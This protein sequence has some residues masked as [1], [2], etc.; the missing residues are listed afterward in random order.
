MSKCG[1]CGNEYRTGTMALVF[2]DGEALRRRVCP[3]CVRR[4]VLLVAATAPVKRVEKIV[5]TE[6]VEQTLR[7]LRTY[8]RMAKSAG[9]DAKAE[10]IEVAIET[11]TRNASEAA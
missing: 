4:G 2:R 8:A 1:A 3:R 11:L 5:R 9:L 6:A 7:M 10:G